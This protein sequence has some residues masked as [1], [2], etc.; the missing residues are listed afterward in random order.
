MQKPFVHEVGGVLSADIAVPDYEREL[1]F[2]SQILT[3]GAAPLWRDDLM[4]NL[5][6][7]VIG[8]G[9]RVP[10]Y[11]G[12]PLQWMPHFQVADVTASANC[13]IE[14]GGNEIMR[15]ESDEWAVLADGV[16]AA[17]GLI[18]VVTKESN[19]LLENEHQGCIGGLTLM[20]PDAAASSDFYQ[21]VIGWTANLIRNEDREGEEKV[22][23]MRIAND[24]TAAA[25]CQS[26]D[27]QGGIPAVW[28]IHLP[29]GDLAESLRRVKKAGGE[30]VQEFSDAKYAVVRDPVGVCLALKAAG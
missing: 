30:I 24:V 17:F 3:T 27:K 22:F 7:P 29:V 4:N 23:E 6:A 8:L 5:G 2:Y 28:L 20:V 12:L 18:P 21:S 13:A 1:D 9:V 10:E 25:I 15:S 16:G 19:A 26:S 11:E 14:M